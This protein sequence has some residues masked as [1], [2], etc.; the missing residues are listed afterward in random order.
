MNDSLE[1]SLPLDQTI[2]SSGALWCEIRPIAGLSITGK[3]YRPADLTRDTSWSPD[4]SEPTSLLAV[5]AM[6]IEELLSEPTPE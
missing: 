5:D 6:A 4:T 3:V 1:P 2:H